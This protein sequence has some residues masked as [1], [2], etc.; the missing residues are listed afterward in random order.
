MKIT[1]LK[2]LL[3]ILFISS[4]LFFNL[5]NAESV[6]VDTATNYPYKNLI[7]RTGDV[8]VFYIRKNNNISCRV[9]VVLDKVKWIS[10]EKKIDKELFTSELLSHCLSRK[11]AEQI[12]LQTFLQFGRGL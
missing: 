5:A 8:K 12:L 2:Y 6:T 11:T 3:S 7:D 1:L 10:A 9:E 4:S